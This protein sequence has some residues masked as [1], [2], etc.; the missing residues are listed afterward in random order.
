MTTPTCVGNMAAGED[1]SMNTGRHCLV[2]YR[3]VNDTHA[4]GV[5]RGV[6]LD[7]R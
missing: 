4:R 7:H 5:N 3:P 1:V 2:K 6:G